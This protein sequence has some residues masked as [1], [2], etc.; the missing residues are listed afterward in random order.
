MTKSP[1]TLP[2]FYFEQDIV[3]AESAGKQHITLPILTET[4]KG[5]DNE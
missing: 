5:K 1:T 3:F 4:D 2:I